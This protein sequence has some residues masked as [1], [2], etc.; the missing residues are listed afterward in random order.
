MLS[1]LRFELR[2]MWESVTFRLAVFCSCLLAGIS[3]A[4]QFGYYLQGMD[5][6]SVFYRWIGEYNLTFG[7]NYM[8]LIIPLL[9][10]L[11]YSHSGCTDR[12]RGYLQHILTRTSR[13]NYFLAKFLITVFS[14]GS[15]FASGVLFNYLLL[16]MFMPI[17]IPDPANLTSFTDPF[18]FCSI[19]YYSKPHLFLAAWIGVVFLWGS[20]MAL[21]GLV[22]GMFT[23]H[24]ALTAVVP[25][26]LFISEGVVAA[27][28]MQKAILFLGNALLELTWTDMLY[29]GTPG[30]A[31]TEY[32]LITIGSI[33]GVAAVIYTIRVNRYECL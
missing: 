16:T 18:R 1:M 15:I 19:W 4:Q 27:Y 13:R 7:S 22:C 2:R 12:T 30:S 3:A 17:E 29:A 33:M 28:V 11:G 21:I 8:F 14:G 26:L 5:H 24:A 25:F 6:I 32:I 9:S 31:P 10:A 23:H 20:A